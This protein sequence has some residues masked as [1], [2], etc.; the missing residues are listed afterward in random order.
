MPKV[1][2]D[3]NKFLRYEK[4][5]V[6]GVTNM[7][8]WVKVGQLARLTKNEVTEIMYNYKKYKAEWLREAK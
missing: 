2:I 8:D 4:V 5:R 3:K 6:S 1:K 7:F